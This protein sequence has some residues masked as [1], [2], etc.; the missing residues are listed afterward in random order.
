[1][2]VNVNVHV[3]SVRVTNTGKM[4][5][6]EVVFLYHNATDPI[7]DWNS[8]KN[9]SGRALA[10]SLSASSTSSISTHDPDPIA[11]KQLVG[12]QRVSLQPGESKVYFS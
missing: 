10:S 6:D 8:N 5:G 1:M 7:I 12:F 3:Q 9:R 4:A 11:L 2:T